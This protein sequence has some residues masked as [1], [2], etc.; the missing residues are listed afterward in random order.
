[1]S[2]PDI[3]CIIVNY[4]GGLLLKQCVSSLYRIITQSSVSVP[5]WR[6][7]S[8]FSG[9]VIIVDNASTDGSISSVKAEFSNAIII[10]NSKNIGYGAAINCGLA[11]ASGEF[12]AVMNSDV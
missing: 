2:A 12:C 7:R 4:N 8:A 1:M 9:E 6:D 11:A 5:L 3:S 10:E